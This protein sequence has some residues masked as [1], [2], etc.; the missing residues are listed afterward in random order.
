MSKSSKLPN[1]KR[2]SS[3]IKDADGRRVLDDSSRRRRLS[4]YLEYLEKDNHNDDPQANLNIPSKRY[5]PFHDLEATSVSSKKKKKAKGHDNVQKRLRKNFAALLE[6]NIQQN[7]D[8]DEPNYVTATAPPPKYPT[9]KFCHV[10]GFPSNYICV[11]CGAK[12]CSIKCLRI[13][14]DTRCLKWTV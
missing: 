12:Y 2:E 6:E 8:S 10:C 5:L 7:G 11:T 3:R 9:R 4:R 1:E 14:Q 13:H